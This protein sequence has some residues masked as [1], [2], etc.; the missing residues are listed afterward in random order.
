MEIELKN[1]RNFILNGVTLRIDD[2]EI[3]VLV[4]RT[5]AGKTTL[6][7]VIAGL[8]PYEGSVIIGGKPVDD[9]PVRERGVG[10]LFQDAALFPHLDVKSNISY[11]LKARKRPKSEIKGRV[12]ELI[13]LVRIRHI[14]DRYTGNLSGGEKRRV[15][16]A[17]ALAPKPAILLMDE[18]FS[19][20]DSII[21]KH[22]RMEFRRIQKKLGITTIYVTHDL[23]EAEEMAHRIAVIHDGILEQV[24]TPEEV[25]FS[26]R[27]ERVHD[28]VGGPN[29]LECDS[30]RILGHG[31]AEVNSGGMS[32]VVPYENEEIEKIVIYPDDVY[33][34]SN[35]LPGPD[36]NRFRGTVTGVEHFLS[37]TR[38]TLAVDGNTLVSEMPAG[39]FEGL[40]IE[41]D[42]EVFLIL[43]FRSVRVVSQKKSSSRVAAGEGVRR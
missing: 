38:L 26:P 25:F 9:V 13:D 39:L 3:L 34:S 2:G 31:L 7:N 29:I 23:R 33:V 20:L 17:R 37:T 21:A 30:C 6:L 10:Y 4:G 12:D 22:L 8:V 19:S 35:R 14:A 43:K 41:I 27:N 18:P 1:I 24:G 32:I 5:G 16:L 40:N 42:R 11:G 36:I 15:A 28:F